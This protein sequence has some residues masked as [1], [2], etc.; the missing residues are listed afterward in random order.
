[1]LYRPCD[2]TKSVVYVPYG[3]GGSTM[4]MHCDN[5][6]GEIVVP[7][8]GTIKGVAFSFCSLDCRKDFA[9]FSKTIGIPW[10]SLRQRATN[11]ATPASA[12]RCFS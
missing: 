7:A 4:S 11:A 12:S 9:D 6:N 10:S 8:I 1:M 2:Q 5:C 3:K